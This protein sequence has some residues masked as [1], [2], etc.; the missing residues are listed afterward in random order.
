[1]SNSSGACG[2]NTD[3]ISKF[4]NLEANCK[5]GTRMLPH[6]AG[7]AAV[8]VGVAAAVA[9]AGAAAGVVA[10]AAAACMLTSLHAYHI[11][12]LAPSLARACLKN[13]QLLN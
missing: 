4:T 1:M 6:F 7:W 11:N 8:A 5:A 13:H 9:A 2:A 3:V 10:A 12:A